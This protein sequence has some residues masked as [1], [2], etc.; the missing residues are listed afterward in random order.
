MSNSFPSSSLTILMK[1]SSIVLMVIPQSIIPCNCFFFSIA[2]KIFD[3]LQCFFAREN[4]TLPLNSEVI[5]TSGATLLTN[6]TA[7]SL[8]D[9]SNVILILNPSPNLVFNVCGVPMHCNTPFLIMAI[10]EDN[11][12]ASSIECVVKIIDLPVLALD[13]TSQRA[14]YI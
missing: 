8:L 6:F 5:S 1:T 9:N 13:T 7:R 12:S 3:N 10:L 4:A 2:V 14:M 11:T